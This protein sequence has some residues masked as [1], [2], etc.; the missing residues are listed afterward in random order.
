MVYLIIP[1][2]RIQDVYETVKAYSENLQKY[3]HNDVGIIIFDDSETNE[4]AIQNISKIKHKG[5]IYYVGKEEK[6]QFLNMTGITDRDKRAMILKP[7]YGGN[8]NFGVLYTL[9]EIYVS[10]DDDMRPHLLYVKGG[11]TEPYQGEG[12]VVARGVFL[13][14]NE[15]YEKIDQDV[16]GAFLQVLGKTIKETGINLVGEMVRDTL[17]DPLTNNTYG[18]SNFKGNSYILIPGKVDEDSLIK[19]AQTLRTG[20]TDVDAKDYAE[21]YLKNP[22]YVSK[23]DLSVVY[24]LI[25]P[26]GTIKPFITKQNLRADCG[27]S[28]YDN[29]EGLPPFIPTTLRYEDYS[30]RLWGKKNDIAFAHVGA[31]QTH[32]RNPRNR[33]LALDVLKEVI[34]GFLKPRLSEAIKEIETSRIIFGEVNTTLS[35]E[36]IKETLEKYQQMYRC[37]IERMKENPETEKYYKNFSEKLQEYFAGFDSEKFKNRIE[38]EMVTE[39]ENLKYTMNVWP[40]LIEESFRLKKEGRLPIRKLS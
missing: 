13:N 31:V 26:D 2:Y 3:G 4:E 20:S 32:Y 8:R 9:G 6:A 17:T 23:N 21:D 12:I 15:K 27:V 35:D 28:G 11:E 16:M 22:E 1:T 39:V 19:A 25:L 29:R 38:R 36:E 37:A 18:I 34:T 10:V 24:V 40:D 33:E 14:R 30:L 7:S 5:G